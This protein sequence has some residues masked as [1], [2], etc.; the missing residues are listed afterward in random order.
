M[1]RKW[2]EKQ[3]ATLLGKW[4]SLKSL[5]YSLLII[6]ASQNT[7]N[8]ELEYV[9]HREGSIETV[10]ASAPRDSILPSVTEVFPEGAQMQREISQRFPVSFHADETGE[11]Y[12]NCSVIEWGPFHPLLPQPIQFKIWMADEV[13]RKTDL[14]TGYNY[15][16]LEE[17]CIGRKP[18]DVLEMLERTS[19]INGF[20]LGLAFVHAVEMIE[21]AEVP[22]KAS[23]L[24]MFLSEMNF[25][26]A[27][28]LS[29]NHTARCLGLLACSAR[30]FKL[31]SL[32][33]EATALISDKPQFSG[34]L[35]IGGLARDIPRE[36]LF[37][38]HAVLQ[39]LDTELKDI[40]NQWES[41]PAIA[42]RLRGTGRVTRAG[43]TTG[44]LLRA[45]G[46]SEDLRRVS[47]LPWNKLSYTMP[48]AEDNDCFARAM[49]MFDDALL[50]LD[51]LEQMTEAVP[52]GAVKTPC[53]TNSPGD[54]LICEPEAY[55]RMAVRI[56]QEN[57]RLQSVRIC[58]AA[59]LNISFLPECLKGM[60]INDLP[61]VTA[62][63]ELDLSAM[64][65]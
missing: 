45:A 54:I 7:N 50:S 32:Y 51:L 18:E 64:E 58:N 61:L 57:G 11:D 5:G 31:I 56:C 28:L 25:L 43:L 46:F 21:N 62:T 12:N 41:T 2:S 16:G 23:W 22:E 20:S 34:L 44:R 33:Q 59:A 1:S 52:K 6:D 27:A 39:E 47:V 8:V 13:V 10:K 19:G 40:R 15:R 49:L 48:R 36:T 65:K 53:S 35:E 42:K 17:L 3:S 24:R 60:E 63:F 26:H 38:V 30:I 29:L 14:K 4:F 55:G 37:A 9:L